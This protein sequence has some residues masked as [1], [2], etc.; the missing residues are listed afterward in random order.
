MKELIRYGLIGV[1]GASLDFLAYA[2][3]VTWTSIQPGVASVLSVSL[4]IVNNFLLNYFFNFAVRDKFWLRLGAFFA[5]GA[6]GIVISYVVIEWLVALDV[7]PLWAKV[8]S[9]PPIVVIQ[10]VINKYVSFNPK[11]G[12]LLK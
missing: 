10:F 7:N 4:G 11:L 1:T 6:L 9:I 3:L 2:A 8:F 12:K 5:V